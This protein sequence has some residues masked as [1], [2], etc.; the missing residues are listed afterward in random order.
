[1]LGWCVSRGDRDGGINLPESDLDE[2]Q[3][4][5]CRGDEE[6]LHEGV[7]ERDILGKEVTI[8]RDK[9]DEVEKLR[10]E[11]YTPAGSGRDDLVKEDED[12]GQVRQVGCGV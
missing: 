9:D 12:G 4:V 5:G 8:P 10:F 2:I 3:G 11:G 7:V 1:V 6:D